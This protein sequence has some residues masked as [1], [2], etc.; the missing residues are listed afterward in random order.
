MSLG[1]KAK[2]A[3][4]N[5]QG[6]VEETIGNVTGDVDTQVKGQ[7]KQVEAEIRQSTEDKKDE[8]KNANI[9]IVSAD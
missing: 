3:A 7:A 1:E 8:A 6:K 9:D 2:A 4:E 5:L